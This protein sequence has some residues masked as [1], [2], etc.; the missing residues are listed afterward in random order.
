M[1]ICDISM[2]RFDECKGLLR[3]INPRMTDEQWKV[4]FRSPWTDEAPG[5]GIEVDG[6][7]GGIMM[8]ITSTREIEGKLL[9]VCAPST[10]VVAPEYRQHSLALLQPLMA[11]DYDIVITHTL[12][13]VAYKIFKIYKLKDYEDSKYLVLPGIAREYFEPFDNQ[14]VRDHQ[15]PGCIALAAKG[16]EVILKR[17][18]KIKK[19]VKFT[20]FEVLYT[21]RQLDN[22]I[23]K[24]LASHLFFRNFSGGILVDSRFTEGK[25]RGFRFDNKKLCRAKVKHPEKLDNL[26]SELATMHRG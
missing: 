26:Y 16:Y 8:L 14:L 15:F 19:G 13:E 7:I 22:K 23:L 18:C 20:F 6:V 17:I 2:E 21:N 25:I 1:N 11:R 24:K 5:I 3:S 4:L 9:K 12:S 10:W